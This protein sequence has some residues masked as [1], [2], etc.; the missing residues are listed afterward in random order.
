[1]I[2][3]AARDLRLNAPPPRE[4]ALMF[5]TA[6]IG[7]GTSAKE[8]APYVLFALALLELLRWWRLGRY[9]P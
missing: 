5:E 8:V 2:R 1:M 4:G 3:R 6:V 9:I 7:L